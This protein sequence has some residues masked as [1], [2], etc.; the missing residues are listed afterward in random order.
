MS[1]YWC[2]LAVL[3]VAAS[4]TAAPAAATDTSLSIT[5]DAGKVIGSINKGL[6]GVNHGPLAFY[7]ENTVLAERKAVDLSAYYK[8]IGIRSV[9]LDEFAS[10]DIQQLFPDF[11]A[12]PQDPAKYA[13]ADADKYLKAICDVGAEIV[14]RL[15]YSEKPKRVDPPSDFNKWAEV[16]VQVI[17]H[18]NAGWADGYTWNIKHWEVWNEPSGLGWTGTP[19]EYCALYEATVKKIKEYDPSLQVGGPALGAPDPQKDIEFAELFIKYCAE[20]QLPL[21]FFSWH[22]YG[23]RPQNFIEPAERHRKNLDAAGYTQ[24]KS[25]LTEWGWLSGVA[26]YPPPVIDMA[27]IQDAA[28]DIAIMAS[29]HNR[30]DLA[31][32]YVGGA[33]DRYPWG[34]FDFVQSNL[35]VVGKPRK[36]YYAFK[37]FGLL[38]ANTLR[39]DCA[40]TPDVDSGGCAV[41]ASMN[42]EKTNI[43]IILANYGTSTKHYTV[44]LANIPW[45]TPTS[46]QI[47]ALDRTRDLEMVREAEELDL[48]HTPIELDVEIPS[49][50]LIRLAPWG[51]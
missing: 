6:L 32:F 14:F 16:M 41:M 1:R 3:S 26:Y 15:G 48:P 8:T 5:V 50:Y 4:V 34:L 17:K 23:T 51:L 37:A 40:A 2:L 11:S 27:G 22:C 21:D 19:L 13:F 45:I 47:R 12:D 44:A 43:T 46:I 39:L 20:R 35:Q 28:A 24:T 30:V 10:I 49:V 38:A 33:M 31:H 29:L 7:N 42:E 18:Y 25:F 36:S 9:R